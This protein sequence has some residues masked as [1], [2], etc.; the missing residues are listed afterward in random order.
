MERY[1]SVL[2]RNRV[3]VGDVTSNDH[4]LSKKLLHGTRS[5]PIRDRR[6]A[7][8]RL[9]LRARVRHVVKVITKGLVDFLCFPND[10]KAIFLNKVERRVCVHANDQDRDD[11]D[12]YHSFLSKSA[13]ARLSGVMRIVNPRGNLRQRL[14]PIQTRRGNTP[15][16]FRRNM[17]E[18]HGT[19]FDSGGTISDVRCLVILIM[20]RRQGGNAFNFIC[21]LQ[22]LYRAPL[23]RWA[24][25]R[26]RRR[27]LFRVL[28]NSLFC[29]FVG[30]GTNY[31]KGVRKLSNSRRKGLR[32]LIARHRIIVK[33]PLIFNARGSTRQANV[34]NFNVIMVTFLHNYRSVRAAVLRRLRNLF[35]TIFTT[36][37]RDI[38]NS[39]Q[40]F[41]NIYI[42]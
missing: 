33:R 10:M 42:S 2:Q 16:A 25:D 24:R 31:G 9:I 21:P 23:D 15:N 4:I 28:I 11:R 3:N 34:I 19:V 38:R 13:S 29:H 18:G 5:L 12:R 27:F 8:R 39:Y 30:R 17:I 40:N 26:R 20:N 22:N 32:P 36:G 6:Q 35:R 41:R 1:K 14:Y 7:A 37:K